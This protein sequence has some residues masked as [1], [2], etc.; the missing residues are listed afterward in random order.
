MSS[1]K[2]DYI[3]IPNASDGRF[4]CIDTA[5]MEEP[6]VKNMSPY[7][8][9]MV[10]DAIRLSDDKYDICWDD[11]DVIR[12]DDIDEAYINHKKMVEKW[13]KIQRR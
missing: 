4:W 8:E 2:R 9:T 1:I 5:L 3:S 10:F 7:Y 6:G 11:L 13:S 12:T